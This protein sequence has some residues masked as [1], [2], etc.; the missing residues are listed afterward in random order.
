VGVFPTPAIAT[1]GVN[2]DMNNVLQSSFKNEGN[3][4]YL[5][6]ETYENEFGASLYLKEIEGKIAGTHPKVDF[7]AEVKLWDT[8][9][10]ANNAHLLESAKDVNVGGAAIALAKMAANSSI[11]A[12]VNL[13]TVNDIDMFGESLS[14]AIV[15]V[16][17]E[18]VKEFEKIVE[19]LNISAVCIGTTGG[20]VLDINE[21]VVK[22]VSD[23]KDVYFNKFEQIINQDI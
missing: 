18:N 14:R 7:E 1:V 2:D 23:L 13:P 21:T 11:G 6:G 9:I 3:F 5:L 12:K 4:I 22:N 19:D 20:D 8:V 17:N 15:E 16:K 10:N